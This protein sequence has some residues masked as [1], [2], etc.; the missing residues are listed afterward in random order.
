MI[1]SGILWR[2][3]LA[4]LLASSPAAMAQPLQLLDCAEVNLLAVACEESVVG[5][6]PAPADAPPAPAPPLFTLQTMRPDTPPLLVD[7]FNDPSDANIA[8]FLEWEHRY[9]SRAFE[10]EEKLKRHR[11]QRT[12]R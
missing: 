11:Q 6:E 12:A 9:L 10:V 2:T 7:V 1:A 3:T 8:A 4:L 5:D